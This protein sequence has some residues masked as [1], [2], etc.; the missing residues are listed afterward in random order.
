MDDPDEKDKPDCSVKSGRTALWMIQMRRT[1]RTALWSQAGRL[2]G[3]RPDGS[4]D[5]PDEKDKPD[6]SVE[7]G[8][9]ALW[10]IQM[11]RTSRTAL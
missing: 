1:S 6:G 9:T 2:C 3:V 11:R 8:R 4:V 5:D 10:V 7:S